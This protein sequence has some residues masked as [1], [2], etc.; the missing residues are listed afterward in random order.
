VI[1]QPPHLVMLQLTVCAGHS[2]AAGSLKTQSFTSPATLMSFKRML[3]VF[4][5]ST[6]HV[7]LP[8]AGTTHFLRKALL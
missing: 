6:R 1:T 4:L 5:I 2:G 7:T 8:A 3:P